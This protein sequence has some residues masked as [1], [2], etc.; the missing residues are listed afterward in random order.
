MGFARQGAKEEGVSIPKGLRTESCFD[1]Y[2]YVYARGR[3][4][5]EGG[6]C[7]KWDAR[8]SY[9]DKLL[10]EAKDG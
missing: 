9:I 1:D 7:C 6:A 2:F 8:A 3:L 10:R 4:V 5:W